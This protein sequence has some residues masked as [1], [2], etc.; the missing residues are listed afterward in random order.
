MTKEKA[1]LYDKSLTDD[2]RQTNKKHH[3]KQFLF[4][5]KQKNSN[6]YNLF[7]TVTVAAQLFFFEKK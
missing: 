3:N 4:L 7:S 1:V 5:E 6:L 2:S